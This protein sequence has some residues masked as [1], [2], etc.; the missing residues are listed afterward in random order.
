VQRFDYPFLFPST[1]KTTSLADLTD[2]PSVATQS[3]DQRWLLLGEAD[4]SG[5]FQEFDLSNQ[6]APVR[7]E[8][9]LPAATFNTGDGA[10]SWAVVDWAADNQ[11]VLLEHDFTTDKV[12]QHEY[13]L[14]DRDTPADSV[15]LT[16]TLQLS[17]TEVPSLYNDSVSQFYI[18]DQAAGTLRR[19]N[20]SD[21]S[22]VSKYDH[23][24][25]FKSFG[26]NM[27]LY[28][29]DQPPTGKEVAG[30][31][32]A[33]LLDGQESITLRTLP[34]GT[35]YSL[36]L[37]QYAGDWYVGIGSNTDTAAYIYKNPQDQSA[38]DVNTNLS[39]WRSLPIKDPTYIDFSA[40]TQ[41]LLA[42]SGQEFIVYDL[43]NVVQYHYHASEPID[44][45]QTHATWMDGDRLLYISNGKLE[46]F[47][48]DYRNRQSLQVADANYPVFF[49]D[50]YSYVY[51]LRAVNGDVKPAL[52][53]TPLTV[54]KP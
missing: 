20:A 51:S 11:H 2:S 5:S 49:A 13:I 6:A 4:N 39:P 10:Q 22:E 54:T 42:E 15:N 40:N 50:D 25:A 18:Y 30:Q 23:I 24:L 41:F 29:T 7:T 44:Q 26:S 46:V 34:I 28:V 35:N 31:V 37:A 14:L 43:E 52:M 27:L 19:V 45:P 8:I 17:Q 32:S 16:S 1:L 9:S 48:Y 3:P 33:V 21:G 38:P 12:T 47:D 36:N 53:S